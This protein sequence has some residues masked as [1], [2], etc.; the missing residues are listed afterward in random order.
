MGERYVNLDIHAA[1]LQKAAA[2]CLSKKCRFLRGFRIEKAEGYWLPPQT[3]FIDGTHIKANAVNEAERQHR[4]E[5][6]DWQEDRQD[7][8]G[9]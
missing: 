7:T 4:Q 3:G 1:A 9:L 8:Y 2:C 5:E 6:A